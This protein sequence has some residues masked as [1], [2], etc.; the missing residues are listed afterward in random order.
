MEAFTRLSAIARADQ[1]KN[2]GADYETAQGYMKTAKEMFDK[3]LIGTDDFKTRAAYLDPYGRTD[4]KTF[5]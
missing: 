5:E 2:E 4:W 1:T 3:G